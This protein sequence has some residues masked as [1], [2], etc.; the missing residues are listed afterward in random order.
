MS[1]KAG[2]NGLVTAI[3]ITWKGNIRQLCMKIAL[4]TWGIVHNIIIVIESLCSM[5]TIP[6]VYSLNKI[7]SNSCIIIQDLFWLFTHILHILHNK[8]IIINN[9]MN[10]FQNF[11]KQ[12]VF[13]EK[14]WTDQL[15]VACKPWWK[16]SSFTKAFGSFRN[17]PTFQ[18]T[19]PTPLCNTC[20]N[21]LQH[22][23]RHCENK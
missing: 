20:C 16:V 21:L 10:H 14:A 19:P 8:Y 17:C 9:N 2:A 4:H 1:N 3:T 23:W 12:L 7:K 5:W 13:F 22:I 6:C 15:L 18:M 11:Q